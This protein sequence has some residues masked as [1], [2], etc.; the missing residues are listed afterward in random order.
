MAQVNQKPPKLSR[1]QKRKMKKKELE[2]EL[3]KETKAIGK[4]VNL[5]RRDLIQDLQKIEKQEQKMRK[6]KEQKLGHLIQINKEVAK[7]YRKR[8]GDRKQINRRVNTKKN[9]KRI[10]FIKQL[11]QTF[12]KNKKKILGLKNKDDEWESDKE[13]EKQEDKKPDKQ[14][15]KDK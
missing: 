4:W 1:N 8:Q 2:E 15:E 9:K 10:S 6:K 3:Q 7:F 14:K 13:E 5:Q 11:K 12:D